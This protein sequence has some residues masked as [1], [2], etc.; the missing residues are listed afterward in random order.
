M[1]THPRAFAIPRAGAVVLFSGLLLVPLFAACGDDGGGGGDASGSAGGPQAC[2]K[3]ATCEADSFCYFT[4]ATCGTTASDKGYC[5]LRP[6][7]C[8]S[9][10]SPACGC[11]G[12]VYDNP[13]KAAL[14]GVD[15]QQQDNT[16]TPPAGLF[17]CGYT[18]CKS[19]EQLCRLTQKGG[20]NEPSCA[21]LPEACK[22]PA[23]TSCMCMSSSG[24][25][26]DDTGGNLTFTCSGG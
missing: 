12:K 19:G 6:A 2:A 25:A 13:C 17:A 20:F 24:C 16:C 23:A 11:D 21:A 18:F 4:Y 1:P 26:C 15:V 5:E 9:V 22:P 7:T 8:D 14:A 3:G 10:F